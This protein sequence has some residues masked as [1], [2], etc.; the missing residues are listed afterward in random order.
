VGKNREHLA[1]RIKSMFLEEG[2]L[3]IVPR[4]SCSKGAAKN[5]FKEANQKF[6]VEKGRQ[7]IL[8]EGRIWSPKKTGGPWWGKGVAVVQGGKGKFKVT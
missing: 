8:R 2:N 4:E 6:L 1:L 7:K 5:R 3:L